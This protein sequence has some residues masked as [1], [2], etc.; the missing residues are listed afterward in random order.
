MQGLSYHVDI[1]LCID[2]TGSMTPILGEVKRGALKFHQ[3]L[4]EAMSAKGKRIDVLRARVVAF[5]DFF[6]ASPPALITSS[7]LMLPDQVVEFSDV[8]TRLEPL[9][10]ESNTESGL[11]GLA[12]ALKS[13]WT[14][15][16]SRR[17]HIT[18]LWTD[19]QAHDLGGRARAAQSYP[20]EIPESFDELTDLW[21]SQRMDA[22]A[23][24][25]ILYAPDVP[26]WDSVGSNWS[27]VIHLPSIAGK[28]LSEFTYQEILETV[29]ASV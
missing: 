23:K 13:D 16:G 21:E 4:S 11:E 28:G 7:F 25:L 15:E 22:S 6:D 17:R 10:G 14:K 9:A 12:V 18:V 27:Q 29:A 8:V 2:V 20:A 26:P 24:R 5:R 3:D 1:A 19:T